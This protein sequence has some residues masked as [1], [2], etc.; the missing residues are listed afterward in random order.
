[1][2]GPGRAGKT[3]LAAEVARSCATTGRPVRVVELAGVRSPE[4][5]P[6][7]V[8]SALHGR[9]PSTADSPSWTEFDGLV[10]LDN[11]EH[12]LEAA[13]AK[14][15]TVLATSRAPLGLAGEA[16][17]RVRALDD[18]SAVRLLRGRAETGG[19]TLPADST[20][21]LKLC[22]R[23]DN[24]PLALELAAARLRNMPIE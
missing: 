14:D 4:E 20:L 8:A 15:A 16:V 1:L 3:R 7:V 13:V 5:V 9:S 11:C 23:L 19:A 21:L 18:D 17:H 2:V 10:V 6:G 24:M 22:H 12:L